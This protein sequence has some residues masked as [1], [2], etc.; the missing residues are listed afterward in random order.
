[1][2][3]ELRVTPTN[4][5][6]VGVLM[7]AILTMA[8]TGPDKSTAW[9]KAS[10][11]R[12]YIDS[13]YMSLQ[14]AIDDNRIHASHALTAID[15]GFAENAGDADA[16]GGVGVQ[17]MMDLCTD[18]ATHMACD[19][20][21]CVRVP[22]EGA[23]ECQN[24]AQCGYWCNECTAEF[25]C[26]LVH[27]ESPCTDLC[28]VDTQDTDCDPANY[29]WCLECVDSACTTMPHVEICTD[30]CVDDTECA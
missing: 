15:S 28:T 11:V 7:T 30:T 16:L 1:M 6:I 10:E 14:E 25:V 22:G 13:E 24:D 9:H 5:V 17:D 27:H 4:L 2:R 12:V 23:D 3:I 20:R 18:I 8:Y 21:S 29:N 26:G 19:L